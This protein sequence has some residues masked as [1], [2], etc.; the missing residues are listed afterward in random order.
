MTRAIARMVAVSDKVPRLSR[1]ARSF[2]VASR[3][4]SENDRSPPRITRPCRDNPSV[5]LAASELTPAIAM[6]PSA[7]Q[8]MKT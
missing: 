3:W 6:Q 8:A 5:R 4:I 2:G 7:M 1:K